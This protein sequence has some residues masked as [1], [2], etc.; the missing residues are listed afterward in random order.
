MSSNSQQWN[1]HSNNAI[2]PIVPSHYHYVN[3]SLSTHH[4]QP[5]RNNNS[6]ARHYYIWDA[7]NHLQP[8]II[9]PDGN[10]V[11]DDQPNVTT[12]NGLNDNANI[13]A[14][15][16]NQMLYY[17]NPNNNNYNP[18]SKSKCCSFCNQK[19]P[20]NCLTLSLPFSIVLLIMFTLIQLAIK[21]NQ[22]NKNNQNN[23]S[24]INRSAFLEQ[25]IFVLTIFVISLTLI[26]FIKLLF[27]K[28]N[29]MI[30]LLSKCFPIQYN[31]NDYIIQNDNNV[32]GTH[33]TEHFV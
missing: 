26:I 10:Q 3:S 28:R 23:L 31:E 22:N 1:Y 16:D 9:D 12:T 8:I 5:I 18:Q 7:E 17:G 6:N 29:K 20:V 25:I 30:K 33:Y 27:K 14:S 11:F 4:Q 13:S 24:R 19:V 2:R 32:R 15:A 21:S